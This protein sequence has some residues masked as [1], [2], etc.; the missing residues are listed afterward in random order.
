MSS[1]RDRTHNFVPCTRTEKGGV[2]ALVALFLP[3]AVVC[4]GM[5][6]DLGIM[7]CA[8]KAVQSACDLGAL[9]GVQN[10]DWDSLAEGV[11]LLDIARGEATAVQI[12]LE[13]LQNTGGMF[14]EL[15][16]WAKAS[17]PPWKEEPCVTV[18]ARFSPNTQFL[19]WL[20]GLANGISM[21]WLS[22]A[23]VVERT[24]W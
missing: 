5:V 9:A 22:E 20:P 4:M 15:N 1:C 8:R 7:F 18:E 16:V 10:L 12:A 19:R 11:V 17:N 23:A 13:N 2:L 24:I 3:I 21:G 6:V 14:S